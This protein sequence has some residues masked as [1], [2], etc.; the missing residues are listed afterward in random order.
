MRKT[1]RNGSR[2]QITTKHC[3]E[4]SKIIYKLIGDYN[5][6]R[7]SEQIGIITVV[8]FVNDHK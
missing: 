6:G 8:I 2:S 3:K 5:I 1:Y 4:T 7:K